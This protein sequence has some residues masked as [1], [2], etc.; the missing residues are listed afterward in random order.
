[1]FNKSS[2]QSKPHVW[3]LMHVTILYMREFSY[4]FINTVVCAD[5]LYIGVL[6]MHM[7]VFPYLVYIFWWILM[8]FT[9]SS[10]DLIRNS[11]Q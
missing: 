8:L 5:W 1:M 3:S 4:C 2:Y 10:C 6:L 9:L 11:F 7:Y